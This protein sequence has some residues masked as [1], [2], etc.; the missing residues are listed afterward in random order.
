MFPSED[1]LKCIV[2]SDEFQR[3]LLTH[4]STNNGQDFLAT[5]YGIDDWAQVKKK[6]IDK[7]VNL[8]SRY[9]YLLLMV[10]TRSKQDNVWISFYEGLHR[11]ASLLITL[12]SAVFDTTTNILKFKTLSVDYFKQ[13]QLLNFKSVDETPHEHLNK[14][15]EHKISAPMLTEPFPIKYH[16]T[17]S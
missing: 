11:H 3:L 6:L 13:H 10:K 1:K 9:Y 2:I 5:Y 4:A 15:F 8:A 12:L 17:Q 14:I 7:G 16:S